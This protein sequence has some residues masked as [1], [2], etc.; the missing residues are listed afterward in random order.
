MRNA[1]D[2]AELAVEAS[3]VIKET[4]EKADP[5]TE[6]IANGIIKLLNKKNLTAR[7]RKAVLARVEKALA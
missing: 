3:T 5:T 6:E 7:Q 1:F 2:T 4:E